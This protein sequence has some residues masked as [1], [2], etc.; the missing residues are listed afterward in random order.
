MLMCNRLA[1]GALGAVAAFLMLG[2][3]KAGGDDPPPF[4]SATEAYRQ[5]TSAL[6]AGQPAAALPALEYAAQRGVLGAQ[7]KLARAYASGRDVPKD[8][9]KAFSYFQQIADQQADI[10]PSSPIAKYVAEAFVAL[11]QYYLDGIRELPLPANPSYAVDLFRHA[12]SYF[13]NGE[14]QYRLARLYMNGDGVEKNVGLAVNWLATAAKKQHAASQATLGEILWRGQEVR[15][16][17]ARG[18]A[19]I[20]LAHENAVASGNEPE[21]IGELYQEALGK[22]D[23]GTRKDAE[24]LLPELGGVKSASVVP[25]AKAK[26]AEVMMMP[27]SGGPKQP[28]VPAASAAAEAAPLGNG[29]PPPASIGLS[30]GFGATSTEPSGLKP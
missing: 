4:A 3:V 9:A 7:I 16:R 1:L 22:S 30:V 25:A 12:A 23:K 13:G 21:W 27:A 17:R 24:A 14:A 20:M 18:L 26:P 5:G 11:G 10:S 19:L 2:P 28:A 6:K 15:Q 29:A 8:D